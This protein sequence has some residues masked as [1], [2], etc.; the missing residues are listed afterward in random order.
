MKSREN[1]LLK[2]WHDGNRAVVDL[3]KGTLLAV[4]VLSSISMGPSCL[5]ASYLLV[6]H[7]SDQ[8]REWTTSFVRSMA[9][10]LAALTQS[11]LASY[12]GQMER[13]DEAE[14]SE[15]SNGLWQR[16]FANINSQEKMKFDF[17]FN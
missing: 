12:G 17:L 1:I 6:C 14:E 2:Q 11:D 4:L 8:H 3:H 7:I 10:L 13:V 16:A 5:L 15:I 9:L